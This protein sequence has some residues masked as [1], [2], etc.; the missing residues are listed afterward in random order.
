MSLRQLE[1]DERQC[2]SIAVTEPIDSCRPRR[3]SYILEFIVPFNTLYTVSQKNAPT[4][5]SCSFNNYRLT[6][7]ILG[8][9]H[10]QT[11]KNALHIQLSLSL[12][13]YLLYLLLN[14]CNK[15]EA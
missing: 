6:L 11:F 4:S 7:I 9:Q 15:N 13:F 3:Y 12:H 2:Y 8:K 14:S 10:Q 1:L 5:G